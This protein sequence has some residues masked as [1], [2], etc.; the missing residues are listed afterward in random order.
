M[1]VAVKG[2]RRRGDRRRA[3]EAVASAA[4][5]AEGAV[6]GQRGG[7]AAAAR[8]GESAPGLR[9]TPSFISW[10]VYDQE[11]KNPIRRH[12]HSTI[13]SS[14]NVLLSLSCELIV[15]GVDE[16]GDAT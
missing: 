7:G 4:A 14:S 16:D 9:L 2:E 6:C 3:V 8:G 11:K 12:F 15:V 1:V 5:G 10:E 13:G